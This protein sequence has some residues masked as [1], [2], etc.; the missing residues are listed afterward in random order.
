MIPLTD[1]FFEDEIR[2]GFYVPAEIKQ[3][4]GAEITVLNEI[5]RVCKKHGL[6][7]FAA[8]G[9]LL[10]TVRHSNIIPWDDDLDITM[11]RADYEKFMEVWKDEMPEGFDVICIRTQPEH[12]Y[13]LSNVVGKSRICFEKEHLTRFHGFPYISGVDI[14]VLDNMARNPEE[15][16]RRM[17]IAEYI[18]QTADRM[19]A[20]T[21]SKG[22][23]EE[24]FSN[25]ERWCN[26]H[27]LRNLRGIEMRRY[28]Y[29]VAE[30]WFAA[31]VEKDSDRVTQIMPCGIDGRGYEFSAEEFENP[32]YI[33]FETGT[34]PVSVHYGKTVSKSY[35]DYMKVYKE[36]S[37]HD[38]PFFEK[39]RED[40]QKVLD[41]DLPEFKASKPEILNRPQVNNSQSYKVTIL[42][43]LDELK[44]M[45][46]NAADVAA[47]QQ[48]A[49]EIGTFTE[50]VKGEGYITVTYMEELCE[51]AYEY[52]QTAKEMNSERSDIAKKMHNVVA[53]AQDIV[54]TRKEV[55]FLPFKPDYWCAFEHEYKKAMADPDMDVYVVPIPYYYKNYDGELRN[56][57]YD[58]SAYPEDLDVRDC[59]EFDFVLHCADVIYIQ[60]PYDEFNSSITVPP[61]FYSRSIRECTNTLVYIPWFK[62]DEFD[63]TDS[64]SYKNMRYYCQMPGVVYADEV[65]LQSV[66]IRNMYIERL[67]EYLGED[68]RSIWEDKIKVLDMDSENENNMDE[69]GERTL[70]YSPDFSY[71]LENEKVAMKTIRR[72]VAAMRDMPENKD[73]VIIWH[74]QPLIAFELIKRSPQLFEQYEKVRAEL[75]DE[76][77]VRFDSPYRIYSDTLKSDED[78][79]AGITEKTYDDGTANGFDYMQYRKHIVELAKRCDAYYGDPGVL[80]HFCNNEGKP[81]T[82]QTYEA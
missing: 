67:C 4:W 47:I 20:N 57:Q 26:I 63:I 51:L 42:K 10:G 48:L 49:I 65:L 73:A 35:K 11:R 27:L 16:M 68:T 44:D 79:V 19:Y 33:P 52:S 39:Q 58:L 45:C 77:D 37:G 74:E 76:A 62:T 1:A 13:F 14:F 25:I 28:L 72:T 7:Y 21:L 40:L 18:I 55:V 3:C 36:L 8:W 17:R 64:R 24:A 82:Y 75:A 46:R 38:Y 61:F 71:M 56:K 12:I 23:I 6:S 50:E 81:V 41:F 31:V 2:E 78:K 5:D 69:S 15:E 53:A 22:E 54:K 9:T 32:V 30:K 29:S 43:A 70:L 66:N 80:A 34:M 60:N 59:S